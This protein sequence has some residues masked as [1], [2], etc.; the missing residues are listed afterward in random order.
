M[1]KYEEALEKIKSQW[2]GYPKNT[3]VGYLFT[4]EFELLEELIENLKV[5]QGE[6][7]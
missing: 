1:N 2:V 3:T 5:L 7:K 6:T 4:S